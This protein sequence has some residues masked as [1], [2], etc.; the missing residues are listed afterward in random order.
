MSVH[1]IARPHILTIIIILFIVII[2]IEITNSLPNIS[3]PIEQIELST[4][5]FAMRLHNTK[6]TESPIVIVAIDDASLNYTGLQWPW[7]RSYLAQ[8]IN[9]INNSN[10]R[11]IGVDIFFSE[12]DSD[13]EGDVLLSNE[14]LHANKSV[15]VM[16]IIRS[17]DSEILSLPVEPYT[18]VLD[19]IG[20]S[21]IIS[22]DDA[23]IRS[24]QLY[25]ES[26]FNQKIYF[27]WAL[28]IARLYLNVPPP[29]N[30]TDDQLLFNNQSI[31]LINHR[32]LIN[33]SG[34]LNT[35]PYYSAYQVVLGDYPAEVFKD[36]I[37]LIGATSMSL[38][39]IYPT[40][41]SATEQT[42]GVEIVA[43]TIDT[44]INES[45]LQIAPP[46]LNLLLIL[47]I[48]IVSWLISR[49]LQPITA[50]VVMAAGMIFYSIAWYTIFVNMHY[51]IAFTTP[52]LMLFLGVICPTMG[53]VVTQELEK[54]R[55]R[56]LFSQ[57]ISPE[58][59]D[60]LIKTQDINSLNK[61]AYLTI[62]FSDIRSFTSISEKLTPEEVVRLLNKYLAVMTEVIHRHGGTVD[63]Y[64]GDAIVAFFGAP[65][66]Y[67]DHAYRAVHAAC[68]MR[69]ELIKLRNQWRNE[70]TFQEQFEIGIG[71]NTGDVFVG[72][73]GSEHRI[74]Y[75][76]IGDA[77]NLASRLQDQTKEYNWPILISGE[78]NK[79][80]KDDFY[81]EFVETKLLKG[82]LEAVDIYKVL[83]IKGSPDD[84]RIAALYTE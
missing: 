31:P 84:D 30:I 2:T 10:A 34:G 55:M 20:L 54:R 36:K 83:K 66:A 74:N 19:G 68:E 62:L 37:V 1:P 35:Y 8:I 7:P 12:P 78:T 75:T 47:I 81:T 76:I 44:I 13:P 40:P 9:I 43:N 22:D 80:I 52:Q 64:E 17:G 77:A 32:M 38:Q 57:F 24:V 69:K 59:V 67:K 53:Q 33:Y 14:L 46:Y 70:G 28:E 72:M 58:M 39:D 51:Q 3:T 61:R 73:L 6:D 15:S 26:S 23:I 63:K 49:H 18:E 25:E 65:I 11:V 50:L 60:Q 42:P 5:D 16:Q 82:K 48:A 4:R 29:I 45:Y 71:I 79:S 41:F 27:N 56:R 21:S